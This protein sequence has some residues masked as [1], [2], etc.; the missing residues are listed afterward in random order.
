MR[1]DRQTD[2]QTGT[3]KLIVANALKNQKIRYIAL[4][5]LPKRNGALTR[6]LVVDSDI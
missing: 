1:T 4:L 3:T 6:F 2:K 5:L